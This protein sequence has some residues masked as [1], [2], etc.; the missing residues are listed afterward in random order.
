LGE[1]L[2]RQIEVDAARAA[3]HSRADRAREANADVGGM[4]HAEGRLAQRLGDRELVHLF[5]VAL[6]QVDNLALG[7]A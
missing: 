5:V 2:G 7:R 6:L 3:R 1:K 4:Q